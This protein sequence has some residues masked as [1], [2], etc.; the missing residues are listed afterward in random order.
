MSATCLD[1]EDDVPL[2]T[3]MTTVAE[4]DEAIRHVKASERVSETM[5]AALVDA[6]LD[7]RVKMVRDAATAAQRR[8]TRVTFAPEAR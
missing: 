6:L 8:E 4:I 1:R 7:A 5:R 2:P 3:P